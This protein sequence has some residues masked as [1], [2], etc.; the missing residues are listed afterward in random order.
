MILDR[1]KREELI[2]MDFNYLE[3]HD[4][5][6][7]SMEHIKFLET[8]LSSL[9]NTFLILE[10]EIL[11]KMQAKI[12]KIGGTVFKQTDTKLIIEEA[13]RTSII[14]RM[15]MSQEDY[16]KC[17]FKMEEQARKTELKATLKQKGVE[18]AQR[19]S[20]PREGE[21]GNSI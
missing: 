2:T 18:N 10:K 15:A 6:I 21:R 4:A 12:W 16:T 8:R 17:K 1:H 3:L 13:N 5:L 11:E 20:L 7:N 19:M 14:N 9:F